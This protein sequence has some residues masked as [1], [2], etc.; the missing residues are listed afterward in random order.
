MFCPHCG[1]TQPDELKFCKSCGVSL[2]AVREAAAM[3]PA[4]GKFDWSRTWVAEM[5]LSE[6]ERKRRNEQIDRERGI[7]PEIK[8][9]TEIKAGVIT[10]SLGVALMI[11]LNVFMQ[12]L[13]LSGKLSPGA[14]E[15]VS[16]LWIAGVLPLFVGVALIINGMFVS[17]RLVELARQQGEAGRDGLM[18]DGKTPALRSADTHE[19]IAP[20]FGVTE[21]TTKHLSAPS[22]KR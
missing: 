13:I 4:A 16:R 22:E 7:T 12:G 20:S 8:R 3:R 11:F 18:S 6:P 2:D 15:I 19:F 1:S 9:H 17:K 21:G 14:A 10:S 5:F